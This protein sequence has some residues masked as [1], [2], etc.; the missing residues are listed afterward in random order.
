MEEWRNLPSE[1]RSALFAAALMHDVAKPVVQREEWGRIRAPRHA[2]KGARMVRV[3]LWQRYL[4]TLSFRHFQL[5]EQTVNLVRHHGLPL[6]LLDESDPSRAVITASQV[7]RL[8]RVALLAEA[9]VLGRK[10]D[11]QQELLER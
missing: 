10:C 9:D 4:P 6:Y 8:D 11:D 1:D 7:V 2:D 5:R 3:L